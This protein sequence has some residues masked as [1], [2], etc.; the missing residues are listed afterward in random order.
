MLIAAGAHPGHVGEHLGHSGIRVTMDVYGH[1]FEDARGEIAQRLQ[2]IHR[3]LCTGRA[4][5]RLDRPAT[6][7]TRRDAASASSQ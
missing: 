4:A 6:A 5:D 7:F 3:G 2:A 1:L